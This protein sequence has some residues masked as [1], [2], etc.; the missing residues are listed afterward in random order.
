MMMRFNKKSVNTTNRDGAMLPMVAVVIVILLVSVTIGVDIARMHLTRSELRTA[1]D[2]AARAA[3]VEI[4][5]S[6]DALLAQDAAILV[7]SR[8][9][10]AGQGLTLRR[11]QIE[12]GHAVDD[13]DSLSFVAGGTKLTSARVHGSRCSTAP[14]G[15][16]DLIFGPIFGVDSFCTDLVSAAT[17]SQRDIGLVLDVS[18]SMKG[19]RFAA[20][21]AALTSFLAVL[22]ASPQEKRISLSVYETEARKIQ[23]LTPDTAAISTAFSGEEA[24]GRTAI[25]KGMRRGLNSLL[26][27]T[28]ARQ[29]AFKS[30]I[31]MTDGNH[32]EGVNPEVVAAECVAA[33]IA[34]YTV[35]FSDGANGERM[36]LLAESADGFHIHANTDAELVAAFE[37][38][39]RQLSVGLIE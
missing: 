1:N 28:N 38:I 17:Q 30:M 18:G 22:D 12:I 15:P 27:D 35:T 23:N 34:V 29:F 39:A 14:D 25:G 20:L 26:N 31:V 32:N 5:N 6:E 7:A 10:V 37:T 16:V 8:N 3:V 9:M 4:A 21:E 2:A 13:G 19:E 33:G 11:D 36:R 24:G